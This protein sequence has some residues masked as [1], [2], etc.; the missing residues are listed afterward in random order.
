MKALV[1]DKT[2]QKPLAIFA[3]ISITTLAFANLAGAMQE[4]EDLK[5]LVAEGGDDINKAEGGHNAVCAWILEQ[6]QR[7]RQTALVVASK[8]KAFFKSKKM[9]TSSN[10]LEAASDNVY[11]VLDTAIARTKA[12]RRSTV[13]AHDL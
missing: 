8:V 3:A 5:V 2:M 12:N 1:H 9:I 6:M 11:I 13:K 7:I 4:Y 10:A